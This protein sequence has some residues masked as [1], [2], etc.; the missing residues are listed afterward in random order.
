[1]KVS[2]EIES[3]IDEQ[4]NT[5]VETTI[6]ELQKL[7]QT[8]GHNLSK[9]TILLCRKSLGLEFARFGILSD[10]SQTKQSQVFSLG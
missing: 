10:D 2:E 5:D 7:L 1:M 8:H 9:S 6:K 4:M 3:I